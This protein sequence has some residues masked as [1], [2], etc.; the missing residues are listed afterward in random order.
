MT[1][2]EEAIV[3]DGVKPVRQAGVGLST[4]RDFEKGETTPI[5]NN[6]AAIRRVNLSYS[7]APFYADGA[8][9]T[10]DPLRP[11]GAWRPMMRVD[12][13]STLTLRP[14]RSRVGIQL[15]NRS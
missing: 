8:F 2:A 5:P 3:P 10:H 13:Y 9:V 6:L 14:A 4:V 7:S 11:F 12:P 1:V 15:A